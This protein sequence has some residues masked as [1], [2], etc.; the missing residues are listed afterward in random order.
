MGQPAYGV[1]ITNGGLF[2]GKG[3]VCGFRK[4]G[5]R[6]QIFAAIG[7]AGSN[8]TKAGATYDKTLALAGVAAVDANSAPITLRQRRGITVAEVQHAV[9]TVLQEQKKLT[10]PTSPGSVVVR[11][12]SGNI[13]AWY[14]DD[15]CENGAPDIAAKSSMA[16]ALFNINSG[17]FGSTYSQPGQPLYNVEYLWGGIFTGT[18]GAPLL[19]SA[20][21]FIGSIGVSGTGAGLGVTNDGVLAAAAQKAVAAFIDPCADK[22]TYCDTFIPSVVG[23]DMSAGSSFVGE[24]VSLSQA[25]GMVQAMTNI[26]LKQRESSCSSVLD[27]AVRVKAFLCMDDAFVGATDLPTRK[28]FSAQNFKKPFNSD[29]QGAQVM[30][31]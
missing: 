31:Q 16:S 26:S 17:D 5:D 10:D 25:A 22:S 21:E 3:G 23:V 13:R 15:G 8:V 1:Q 28:A 7:V 18:S 9:Q 19:T 6:T 24:V 29:L 20:G 12:N 30:I 4:P 27:N 11:D 14:V 2:T